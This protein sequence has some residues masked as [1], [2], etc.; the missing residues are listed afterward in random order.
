MT[1][2]TT[3]IGPRRHAAPRRA[4][5]RWLSTSAVGGVLGLCLCVVTMA[6]GCRA[7]D[8]LV[9]KADAVRRGD[10][11][12]EQKQYGQAISAYQDA[13][14]NDPRDAA[15]H[16]KLA[17]AHR[18]AN[19]WAAAAHEAASAAALEPDN[20]EAHMQ[21]AAGLVGQ[22][23]FADAAQLIAPVLKRD[24]DNAAALVVSANANARLVTVTWALVK[25]E[26]AMRLGQDVEAERFRLRPS[27]SQL[28]DRAAEDAFR[29]AM[30]IAPKMPEVRLGF[31]SFLWAVGRLDEGAEVMREAAD[32]DPSHAFLSRALG[33]YYASRKRDAEAEKYFKAAA[34]T[35]DRDSQLVL[36][37]FL[38]QRDRGEETLAMLDK[39]A[40]GDDPGSAAA[41]RA[42][43]VEVRLGR[44]DQARQ[45][46]EKILQRDPRSARALR[47]KAQAL[48]AA[49]DFGEAAKAAAAA[50]AAE[51]NSRE[52]RLVFARAL[53]ATGDRTR[54]FDEFAEASRLNPG[55][56]V[57]AKEMAAL[58][59]GLGRD[60]VALEYARE[61]VRLNPN[62]RDAAI[63]LARAQVRN[64]QIADADRTVAPFAAK[65]PAPPEVLV[66]LGAIQARRGNSD[67][68]RNTY[69]E[70]LQV[71]G[72]SFEALS[73]LLD[74]EIQARQVARVQPRIDQA[75]AAHPNDAQYLLLAGRTFRAAGDARRA[76]STVR[77]ILEA[78][79]GHAEAALLL[80]DMLVQQNRREEATQLV[81]QTLSRGASSVELQVK[82]AQ[83]LDE[84]GRVAD[85]RKHY[86]DIVAASSTAFAASARLATIYA[87][88]RENLERALKLA[89]DARAQLPN[90]P[91]VADA[92]GWVYVRSGLPGAG[93]PHLDAAVRAEPSTALFRYH[94]GIAH[95]LQGDRL[96]ARDE[97]TRS[98]ALD[99]NFSGAADARAALDALGKRP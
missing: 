12:V 43:D 31:A 73:S 60:Q 30:Q 25:L 28:D 11:F 36:S 93:Q 7:E 68:A 98:L 15:L 82:L 4:G 9:L 85:A 51:P 90:D 32:D 1:M 10:G 16:L 67:A 37:D 72:N 22:G 44:I 80:A 50:A 58:A 27:N 48:L 29:R 53:L 66:V 75:L 59:L 78:N 91:K 54:A 18:L 21:A 81:E 57:I 39:L 83:L 86:E 5:P 42:A 55:D 34:V 26:E 17:A 49:K 62:D 41:L 2:T 71:D 88:Q 70:A 24:P 19:Q 13:L 87:D 45:R 65:R 61:A 46:A 8:P 95:Q 77:K 64:N 23:E 92:L 84:A 69:L 63:L 47:I 20:Q 97:L 79:P 40:A 76:E 14:K 6:A 33:L 56:R 89:K 74:L 99:P 38:A 3:L 96:A 52:A 35:G 94:L